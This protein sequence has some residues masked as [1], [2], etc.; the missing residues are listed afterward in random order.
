V[1][2]QRK[3]KRKGSKQASPAFDGVNT[4]ECLHTSN[5]NTT[6]PGTMALWG[7][8]LYCDGKIVSAFNK[9]VYDRVIV[10]AFSAAV[11]VIKELHNAQCSA[12]KGSQPV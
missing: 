5:A 9:L 10:K 3:Q 8:S 4:S 1:A 12:I 6:G 11:P 7:V 2:P